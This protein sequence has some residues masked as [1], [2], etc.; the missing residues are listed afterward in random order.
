VHIRATHFAEHFAISCRHRNRPVPHSRVQA[1]FEVLL[2]EGTQQVGHA[3]LVVRTGYNFWFWFLEVL[4]RPAQHYIS[5]KASLS[6]Y[7]IF[8][9]GFLIETTPQEF[10]KRI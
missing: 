8:P 4:C 10:S 1:P 9:S 2:Q 3:A 6:L 5:K 7:F